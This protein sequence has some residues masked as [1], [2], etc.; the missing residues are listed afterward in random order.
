MRSRAVS[1]P[2]L[3]MPAEPLLAASE[4]RA[5]LEILEVLKSVHSMFQIASRE[6]EVSA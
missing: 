2:A 4:L 3:L 6:Y 1:L 5:P